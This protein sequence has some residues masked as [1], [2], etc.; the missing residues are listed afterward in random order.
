VP[1]EE[2]PAAAEWYA[3]LKSRPSFRG[4]LADR[5][6]GLPPATAYANLDF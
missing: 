6:P 5:V 2:F 1:W 4:L 3:R